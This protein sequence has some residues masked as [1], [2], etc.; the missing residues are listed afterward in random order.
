VQFDDTIISQKPWLL[1]GVGWVDDQSGKILDFY[2][3]H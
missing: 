2:Y 1:P 3:L